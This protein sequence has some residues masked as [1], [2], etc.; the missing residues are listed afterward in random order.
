M[1]G[2]GSGVT[3]NSQ[4]LITDPT[5]VGFKGASIGDAGELVAVEIIKPGRNYTNPSVSFTNVDSQPAVEVVLADTLAGFVVAVSA[6]TSDGTETGI[7]RPKVERASI[8]FTQ[9]KGSARYTWTKVPGAV[10]YNVYRSI[11][12]PNGADMHIGYA[13]GL[14]GTTRGTRFTD[15][16]LTPDFTKQPLIYRD[17]FAA[18]AVASI[19]V[20]SDG[21][22]Y[23]DDV[24]M[25][26]SGGGTG[27]IGWPIVERGRIIGV[28]IAHHGEG[29]TAPALTLGNTGGGTG[30]SFTVN[31]TDATGTYP[32]CSFRFQG[33]DGYAGSKSEPMTVWASRVRNFDFSLSD[34]VTDDDP[35]EH[36]LD[37]S[38]VLPI[39][40]A[41]PVRYGLMVFTSS[42]V[43]LLRGLENELLTPTSAYSDPQSYVGAAQVQPQFLDADI[44]Y[45]HERYR[46][47]SLMVPEARFQYSTQEVSTLARHFFPGKM[48]RSLS[49]AYATERRGYG[50]YQDGTGFTITIDREQNITGFTPIETDG[51]FRDV[52]VL[53]VGNEEHIYFQIERLHEGVMAKTL[54]RIL[55]EATNEPE[56]AVYLDGCISIPKVFPEGR[57]F[58]TKPSGTVVATAQDHL[59]VPEDVGKVIGALGGRGF[60]TAFLSPLQVEVALT[61]PVTKLGM[62][63][64][65][66]AVQEGEWWMNGLVSEVSGIPYEGEMVG[67]VADGKVMEPRE[68]VDG[69]ITLDYPA[70]IVHVGFVYRAELE[71]LP[72]TSPQA[73]VEG[74]PLSL[75]NVHLEVPARQ[76]LLRRRA[77]GCRSVDTKAGVSQL[78]WSS[79]RGRLR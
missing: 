79:R 55:P 6:V 62:K 66:K 78:P 70:A 77:M 40:Y 47:I 29:Y 51:A 59:F 36:T 8:D 11:V 35:F 64:E 5:G 25:S 32:S 9:T 48:I 61:R 49:F 14:I 4:I 53:N 54:E 69:K 3:G 19:D 46:G 75:N 71:T 38:E 1:K 50:V 22:G 30:A 39:R 27:F 34:P 20:D 58:L 16:N 72:P 26:L 60:I 63:G 73:V 43:T 37:A 12:I 74:K 2:D 10:K 68:V 7:M 17:P 67:V 18:G 52:V 13:M 15:T 31:L 57:L 42:G 24:T 45:V 65:V 41:I 44:L 23:G 56:D 28:Y 21:T 76:F 33:R